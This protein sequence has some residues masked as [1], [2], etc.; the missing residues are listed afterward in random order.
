[1]SEGDPSTVSL[2]LAIVG[3]VELDGVTLIA[4]R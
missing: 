1:V 2:T 4:Q 3:P